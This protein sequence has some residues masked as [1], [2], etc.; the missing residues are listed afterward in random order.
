VLSSG[1]CCFPCVLPGFERIK[2]ARAALGATEMEEHLVGKDES[3]SSPLQT[4]A[5]AR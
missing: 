2:G 1:E 5:G 4:S 3:E